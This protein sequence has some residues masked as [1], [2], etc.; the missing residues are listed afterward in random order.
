MIPDDLIVGRLSRLPKVV[1][2]RSLFGF[3]S[4]SISKSI[5][6]KGIISALIAGLTEANINQM[7]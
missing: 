6:G 5:F 1:L 4:C 7:T 3:D 2:K